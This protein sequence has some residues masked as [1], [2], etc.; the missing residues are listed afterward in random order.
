MEFVQLQ[1]NYLDWESEWVRSRAVYEVA[2]KHNKPVIVMEPVKGGT[3]ASIP[4]EAEKLL[5]AA[6]PEMSI[7]SW[8]IRFAASQPNVMMVLSGMSTLEQVEDNTSFMAD[9]KPLTEEEM[10]LAHRA[11]EIINAKIQ[12]GP[13]KGEAFIEVRQ[14]LVDRSKSPFY[15]VNNADYEAIQ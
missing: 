8:A 9:F 15:L 10:Q 6:E 5:K 12:K 1:I 13:D 7:P 3:L 14:G 4:A 11:A 2:C